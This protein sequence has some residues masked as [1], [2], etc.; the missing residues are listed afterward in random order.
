MKIA[1]MQ[2]YFFPYIGYFQMINVVD[3]FIFYDDVNFIKNGWI[4]RNKILI[5]AT[6]NY[7]TVQLKGAS[8][9][10]LIKDIEFTD[11]R[12][13]LKR[14]IEMSYKKAP[15]FNNA[16]PVIEEI[17]NCKTNLISD[18][19]IKSIVKICE[20]ININTIFELSSNCYV[21]TKN[22]EK[23]V[24]LI[25]ICKLNNALNYINPIGGIGLYNRID[26]N[27]HNIQLEFI[28]TQSIEY[29]QFNH[30]FVPSLSIIDVIMFNPVEKIQDMLNQYRLI[31]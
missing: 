16:W 10:K 28:E 27:R 24:R 6:P 7:L 21:E 2:P 29:K 15:L 25:Q 20:Y 3:K 11:N 4:N 5:N 12:T 22:L 31:N 17:L 26:F 19:A 8:P 9:N 14:T 23:T 18:L 30:Q 1:I 13:K